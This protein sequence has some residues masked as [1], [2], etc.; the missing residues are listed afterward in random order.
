M[1]SLRHLLL[2]RS[3]GGTEKIAMKQKFNCK[4]ANLFL[5]CFLFFMQNHNNA[6]QSE[7]A[8][9]R[10]KRSASVRHKRAP[11]SAVPCYSAQVMLNTFY[12]LLESKIW[13]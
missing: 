3:V 8:K 6:T 4:S 5:L 10:M 9:L 12:G 7:G 11:W 1:I 13:I 2:I